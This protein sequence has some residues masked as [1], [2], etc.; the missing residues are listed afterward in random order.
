MQ[1]RLKISLTGNAYEKSKYLK[2]YLNEHA[3]I[4]CTSDLRM[5][6]YINEE[7]QREHSCR[8]PDLDTRIYIEYLYGTDAGCNRKV[9]EWQNVK[10]SGPK[11][12]N[13]PD[14][15]PTN[16]YSNSKTGHN[17]EWLNFK[18]LW[19]AKARLCNYSL[20]SGAVAMLKQFPLG[21]RLWTNRTNDK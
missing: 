1:W 16:P 14:P 17:A 11:G 13:G 8:V 12:E 6:S 18:I 3:T 20:C 21:P 19:C 4:L 9:G 5:M 10:W 15:H 7:G 2:F